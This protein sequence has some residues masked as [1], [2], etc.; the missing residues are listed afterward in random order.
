M[1]FVGC[2]FEQRL[3]GVV[4]STGGGDGDDTEQDGCGKVHGSDVSAGNIL[5]E[6]PNERG[7]DQRH[8]PGPERD[9][10]ADIRMMLLRRC[11]RPTASTP[12]KAGS[13]S[14]KDWAGRRR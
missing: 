5:L 7:H 4:E 1:E 9:H 13:A 3:I 10:G 2:D 14:E 12:T 11:R 6:H 8:E